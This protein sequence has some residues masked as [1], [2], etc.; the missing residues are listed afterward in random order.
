VS[1]LTRI[2]ARGGDVTRDGWRFQLRRGRLDDAA[3]E[4][5]RRPHVKAALHREVWPDA[6]AFEERAAIREFDAGQERA[7]AEAAAYQDVTRC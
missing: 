3:L 7:E 2:R 6:D 5:L 4:W 1:I